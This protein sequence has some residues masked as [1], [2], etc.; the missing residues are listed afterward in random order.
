MANHRPIPRSN[1]RMQ[2]GAP[3]YA[4]T[5]TAR[6]TR[7]TRTVSI[8]GGAS[9]RFAAEFTETLA[10]APVQRYSRNA[11]AVAIMEVAWEIQ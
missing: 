1:R 7:S 3:G 5:P 2:T 11:A 10:V 8:P 6:G 9:Y 4:A